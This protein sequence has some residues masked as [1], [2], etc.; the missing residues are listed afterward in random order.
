MKLYKLTDRNDQT[1]NNCQWGEGVT[2]ETSGDGELCSAGFTH[3]YTSPLL[4][5][6]L[7]PI[8]GNY[9]LK[10][11]H[12]WAGEGEVIKDNHGLKVGCKKATTLCRISLPEVTLEQKIA[13]GIL[14]AKEVYD[15]KAWN[16]WADKWLSGEDRSRESAR[17]AEFAAEAAFATEA[18]FSAARAAEAAF[19]A[20]EAAAEAAEAA[21]AAFAARAAARAAKAK[22]LNLQA[23]AEKAVREY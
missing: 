17:V 23:I 21:R 2:V 4:A 1:R 15:V 13:S 5:V 8:H 9:Y 16:N 6:L 7:N 10:T 18:A 12:L 22:P 19:F 11:A 20:A 3:W 14:C